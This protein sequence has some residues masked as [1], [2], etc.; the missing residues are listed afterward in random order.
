V[1]VL[2]EEV[3]MADVTAVSFEDMDPIHDGIARR[4]RAALGVTSFG[5]QVMSLPAHWDGY[6]DHRHDASAED[7]DQE[8]VYIPL[9][10]SATLRAGEEEL[11]LRP[12][13][14]V[15]VGPEQRRRIVPGPDGIRFVALGGVP[16]T[17][18]P[19][20]WTEVGGPWPDPANA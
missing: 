10:G 1:S 20:P 4:A 12:G 2:I 19:S 16:G 15:R 13:M 6:P 3:D 17:F 9:E 8:E 11:E 5:M 7:A 18:R 14:M